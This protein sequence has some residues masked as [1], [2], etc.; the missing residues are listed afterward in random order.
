MLNALQAKFKVGFINGT[1]TKPAVD[2][3]GLEN[4]LTANSMIVGWISAS[5]EP[6][7]KLSVT[8]ISDACQLWTNLKNGSQWETKFES[9]RSKLNLHRVGRMGNSVRVLR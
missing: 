9:I 1:L 8:Y 2:S 4:W 7:V 5:I 3:P 6:S